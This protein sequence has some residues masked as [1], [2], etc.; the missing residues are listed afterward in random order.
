MNTINL[1]NLTVKTVFLVA[2]ATGRRRSELHAITMERSGISTDGKSFMLNLDR[3]FLAKSE[4]L[5]RRDPKSL[6]IPSLPETETAER[7]LCPVRA[8][9]TY[10]SRT[11]DIRTNSSAKK[12]FVSYKQGFKGD[13]STQTVSR[14]ISQAVRWAYAASATQPDLLQLHSIRAHEVRAYSTSVA[15]LRAAPLE[16]ILEAAC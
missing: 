16:D 3:N 12:L 15:L 6:V 11:S 1:P 8:L 14:W 9:V 4:R 7:S 10:L 2:L 5:T 13:I